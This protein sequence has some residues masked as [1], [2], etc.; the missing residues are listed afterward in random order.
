MQPGSRKPPGVPGQNGLM[1]V[2]WGQ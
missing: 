1:I 2:T